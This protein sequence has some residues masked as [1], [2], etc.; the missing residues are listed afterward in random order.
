MLRLVSLFEGSSLVLL[1]CIAMPLKYFFASPQMVRVVGMAH[2]LL[3]IS[4]VLALLTAAIEL[5]F[6][7]VK[8]L[9]IFALSF[10]PFGFLKIDQWLRET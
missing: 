8:S 2:G 1:F 6:S 7:L 10:V 3:F 4:F 9:K 5:K